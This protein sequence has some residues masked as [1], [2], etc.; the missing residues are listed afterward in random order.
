MKRLSHAYLSNIFFVQYKCLATNKLW[1]VKN[2][3]FCTGHQYW[4]ERSLKGALAVRIHKT[5][6]CRTKTGLW[7]DIMLFSWAFC[8]ME[9]SNNFN[10]A[11]NQ[12][13]HL[14]IEVA[15]SFPEKLISTVGNVP[16]CRSRGREFNPNPVPYFR[17]D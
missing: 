5:W 7:V 13:V 8:L 2:D 10:Y 1:H 11:A 4:P 9:F 17:G 6:Q 16:D 3:C 15:S 14:Q 12:S